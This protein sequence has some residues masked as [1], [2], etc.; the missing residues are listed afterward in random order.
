MNL[1]KDFFQRIMVP[2]TA[3]D[4]V[5]AK[6]GSSFSTLFSSQLYS[7]L[8]VDIQYGRSDVKICGSERNTRSGE[9]RSMKVDKLCI[10]LFRPSTF[11]VRQD[12]EVNVFL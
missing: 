8:K 1:S 11:Q 12:M 9:A 4:D 3:L 2:P 10:F 7:P 6:S 5:I